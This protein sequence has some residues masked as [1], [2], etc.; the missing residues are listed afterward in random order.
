[1]SLLKIM[2][3]IINCESELRCDKTQQQR[4]QENNVTCSTVNL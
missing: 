1:M 4:Y 2:P 3:K